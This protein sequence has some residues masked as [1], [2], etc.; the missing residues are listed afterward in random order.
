MQSRPIAAS[1]ELRHD[2]KRDAEQSNM[3]EIKPGGAGP[4]LFGHRSITVPLCCEGIN[5]ACKQRRQEDKTLCARYESE[6][7]IEVSADNRRQ[8]C[9]RHPNQH[10]TSCRIEFDSP[11]HSAQKIR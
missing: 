8:M 3:I 11:L 1:G 9:E 4:Q 7:L 5:A 2:H 6:G 10:R